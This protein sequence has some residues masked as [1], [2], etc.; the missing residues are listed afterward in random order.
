MA[1]NPSPKVADCR[2]IAKK[3]GGMDHVIIIGMNTQTRQIALA[4][5]GETV[6]KCKNA[7]RLGDA[8]YKAIIEAY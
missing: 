3:W 5:Y 1:W 2:D 8:A 4:T 7:K 6:E